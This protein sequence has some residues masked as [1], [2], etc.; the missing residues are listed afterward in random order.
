MYVWVLF[1]KVMLGSFFYVNIGNFF[2]S[3][4]ANVT[5]SLNKTILVCF[6]VYL[7]YRDESFSRSNIDHLCVTGALFYFIVPWSSR[8]SPCCAPQPFACHL[9]HQGYMD[10]RSQECGDFIFGDIAPIHRLVV[11]MSIVLKW[12]QNHAK[13]NLEAPKSL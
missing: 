7:S 4:I 1:D 8:C 9:W 5:D 13:V 11:V 6:Y 2:C 3:M 12:H 10:I